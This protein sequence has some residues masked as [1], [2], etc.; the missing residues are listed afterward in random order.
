MKT[1][2]LA[3]VIFFVLISTLLQSQDKPFLKPVT[4]NDLKHSEDIFPITNSNVLVHNIQ[5]QNLSGKIYDSVLGTLDTLSNLKMWSGSETAV[6]FYGQ[7]VLMQW[8]VAP[9]NMTIKAV[10]YKTAGIGSDAPQ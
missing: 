3:F 8:Y 2:I 7:D 9:A 4:N 1:K 5:L 6:A 10:G